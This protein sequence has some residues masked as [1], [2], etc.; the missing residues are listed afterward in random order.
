MKRTIIISGIFIMTCFLKSQ[1]LNDSLLS[2]FPFNRNADDKSGNANHG[3]VYGA[4]LTEDRFGNPNSAYSFDGVDDYIIKDAENIN[5]YFT[6]AGWIYVNDITQGNVLYSERCAWGVSSFDGRRSRVII[7]RYSSV[8]PDG[9]WNQVGLEIRTKAGAWDDRDIYRIFTNNEFDQAGW[10]FICGVRDNNQLRLYVN[11]TEQDVT[12]EDVGENTANEYDLRDPYNDEAFFNAQGQTNG[13]LY[14]GGKLDDIRIYNRVLSDNEIATLYNEKNRKLIAHY[15]FNGNTED[16]SGNEHHAVNHQAILDTDRFGN[17]NSAYYFDGDLSWIE[18]PY[19]TAMYPDEQSISLWINYTNIEEIQMILRSGDA[20]T[21]PSG[22]GWHGYELSNYGVNFRWHDY[23]GSDYN[24]FVSLPIDNFNIDTWYNIVITRS[25]NSAELYVN[26]QLVST[27]EGLIP[28][29][30]PRYSPIRIGRNS[31]EV[32]TGNQFFHGKIDDIYIYNYVLSNYEI[33]ELFHEI[34][35]PANFDLSYSIDFPVENFKTTDYRLIGIPGNVNI[36]INEIIQGTH[37]ETWRGYWDN[38]TNENY[39]QEFDGSAKFSFLPGRGF[40]II[41]KGDL[42]IERSV[43]AMEINEDYEAEILLDHPG[44][45]IISN[46]FNVPILWDDVRTRNSISEPIFHFGGT[47]SWSESEIFEPYTGYYFDN[48]QNGNSLIIPLVNGVSKLSYKRL[49]LNKLDIPEDISWLIRI[50]LHSGEIYDASVS[51]GVS[52]KA[53]SSRDYLDY[54]K[55]RAP[56]DMASVFYYRP[57]WDEGYGIFARDIRP[58]VKEIEMWYFQVSIPSGEGY[59]PVQITSSLSFKGIENVPEEL[60]V[61]LIDKNSLQSI[62][63]REIS[64]YEFTPASIISKFEILVGKKEAIDNEIKKLV[65]DKFSLGNNYPNP[66]NPET[67]IPIHL[68]EKSKVSLRVYNILGQCVRIIVNSKLMDAGIYNI[69]FNGKDNLGRNLPSGI[70]IYT[71]ETDKFKND[72][73]K[74]ILI[75]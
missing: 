33:Q 30:K 20:V 62:D 56:G 23:T 17:S 27:D 15:P 52:P 42:S 65:P 51:L 45:N 73:K 6:I 29:A 3:T 50:E 21:T 24:A 22:D 4:S 37:N 66:F 41:H 68:P 36:P 1:T 34:N 5:R 47:A 57:E 67:T 53:T 11:G 14:H 16:E 28:Y 25:E 39:Y 55:P 31:E 63:L 70:Y 18:I 26:S 43:S 44:W 32:P 2:Y 46:P 49:S 72:A 35:L 12:I 69:T 54:R 10:Y 38:G 48:T 71:I 74:M 9:E 7:Q 58:P 75:K 64:R 59:K 40:W 60:E 13:M 8:N 61:Y 19:D